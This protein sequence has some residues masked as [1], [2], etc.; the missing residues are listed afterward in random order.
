MAGHDSAEQIVEREVRELV[1]RRGLDPADDD[2]AAVR[3]LIDE[4]VADY[5]E[6][7][8]TANLPCLVRQRLSALTGNP[9]RSWVTWFPAWSARPGLVLCGS[10]AACWPPRG[11]GSLTALGFAA[12]PGR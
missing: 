6:R 3:H 1:R 7:S 5:Q 9:E 10:A 2:T 11:S 4:V 8:L 12:W